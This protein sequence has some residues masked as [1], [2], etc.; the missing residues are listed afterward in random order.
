[1]KETARLRRLFFLLYRCQRA[2]RAASA[3]LDGTVR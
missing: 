2:L 3:A 1:M